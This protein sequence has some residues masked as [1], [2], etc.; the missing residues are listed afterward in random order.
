MAFSAYAASLAVG[1]AIE[2]ESLSAANILLCF[3]FFFVLTVFYINENTPDK[4][5]SVRTVLIAL[6]TLRSGLLLSSLKKQQSFGTFWL[7]IKRAED[8]RQ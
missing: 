1:G 3:K 4:T 7:F 8:D 2:S 5:D 6:L